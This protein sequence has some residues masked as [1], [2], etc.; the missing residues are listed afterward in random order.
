[1]NKHVERYYQVECVRRVRRRPH[2]GPH[3]PL[4]SHVTSKSQTFL[5]DVERINFPAVPFATHLREI[6]RAAACFE[7]A[8]YVSSCHQRIEH[9]EQDLAHPAIPPEVSF[10][11][12]NIDEL[13]RIHHEEAPR[14]LAE[15]VRPP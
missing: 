12:C 2:I 4:D 15:T 7:D 3:Q 1:M 9:P 5:A 14:I 13:G 6:S 8:A 11:L 10:R